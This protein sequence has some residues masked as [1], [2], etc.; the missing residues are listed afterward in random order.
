MAN[1]PQESGD[2]SLWLAWKQ[3]TVSASDMSVIM[4]ASPWCTPMLLWKRKMGFAPP[5]EDN[6]AMQRGRELEG[7]VR[8]M[9]NL[10][11]DSD[12]TKKV[13]VHED[14]DYFSAS[15]DGIDPYAKMLLEIKIA[16]LKDHI[17]AKEGKIPS[18]YKPQVHWQLYCSGLNKGY[19]ASFHKEQLILVKVER[20]D[21]YINDELLPAAKTFYKH[22][23][24][25]T[26]PDLSDKDYV[27][28]EGEEFEGLARL[29]R[30]ADYNKKLYAEKEKDIR[31]Q[32]I[33]LSNNV[34]SIGAGLKIT[35]ITRKNS[36][37]WSDVWGTVEKSHPN[38]A[39]SIAVDDYR[40]PAI[41]FW[42]ITD[43]Q[44]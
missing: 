3:T 41:E 6:W 39:T 22:M 40:N 9:V 21:D 34:N 30:D 26:P 14:Y 13:I 33:K 20:D 27:H 43:S 4:N 17:T 36:I 19:Y 28:R 38:V 2:K 16:S 44:K 7:T 24:D 1:I 35:K 37:R 25:C 32:L 42:K 29:W 15:L 12:F 11:L 31:D 23:V 18:K 8:D 10:K 5:Q